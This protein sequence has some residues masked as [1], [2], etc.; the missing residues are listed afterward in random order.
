MQIEQ[1][2][3]Y[4]AAKQV[5]AHVSDTHLLRGGAPLGGVA[6]TV[7]A[8][9]QVVAQLARL[10]DSLDAIVVT[11]DVTDLGEADAYR[12][13]RAAVE[14]L[15]DATGAEL[16]WVMGNH[17]ERGPF[18][19]GLLDEAPSDEPV[20]RVVHVGGL[21]VIALDTSVPG[22]H[23]GELDATS[24]AWLAAVL[25]EPAAE[26]TILAMHHAPLRHAARAHGP[27]RAPRTGRSS[28][29]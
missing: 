3:R 1:L 9:G 16:I 24:L 2:G 11:G 25:A 17:D 28:P 13:V 12:R 8:L 7:S 23:H 6:D 10:G 5:I 18:R 4:P 20:H 27:P 26:G 15:V 21:R 14:P 22:Y 29:T 19:E